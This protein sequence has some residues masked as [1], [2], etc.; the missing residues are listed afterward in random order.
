MNRTKIYMEIFVK[1]YVFLLFFMLFYVFSLYPQESDTLGQLE[2][3]EDVSYEGISIDS[4]EVEI[5][6]NEQISE[7]FNDVQGV[8]VYNNSYE[9]NDGNVYTINTNRKRIKIN[10]DILI[11]IGLSIVVSIII[12]GIIVFN[13][14]KKNNERKHYDIHGNR[15]KHDV[16]KISNRSIISKINS[17]TNTSNR[18]KEIPEPIVSD[19]RDSGN[20][21]HSVDQKR[22]EELIETKIK[23]TL[24]WRVDDL[25]HNIIHKQA[26][27]IDEIE[28]Q[29][30]IIKRNYNQSP[31]P[32]RQTGI[33]NINGLEIQ[34]DEIERNI[35]QSLQI[36]Q[37]Q[38]QKELRRI[39][40]L[41]YQISEIKKEKGKIVEPP[42]PPKKD[43]I[44]I[45]ND[46]ATNPTDKL[47]EEYFCYVA[48]EINILT[49]QEIRKVD[50]KTKWITN[51]N[52][53][54]KY[55]FPNPNYFDDSTNSEVYQ[56][57]LNM[58]NLKGTN[59]IKITRACE[60]DSKGYIQFSGKLEFL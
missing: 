34:I 51:R 19:D 17:F 43:I 56:M 47:S 60:M 59:R 29:I 31:Q 5:F 22:I 30:N 45:F 11:I 28:R 37:Q 53:E 25:E 12:T 55:I 23:T 27:R 58:I 39:D 16:E 52:G 3:N 40:D 38:Q 49:A 36:L 50:Y 44:S 54:K 9:Y 35:R 2:N 26:G 8:E 1:K 41:E 10:H 46:W 48:G 18:R 33:N 42:P 32:L 21:T 13:K 6:N 7:L 57:N 4:R 15:I 20:I 14:N 24:K